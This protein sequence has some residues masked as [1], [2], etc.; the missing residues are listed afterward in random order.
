MDMMLV[1]IIFVTLGIG[2]DDVFVFMDA[3]Q[4]SE[5][6]PEACGSLL[7]RIDYTMHRSTKVSPPAWLWF[8][9]AAVIDPSSD[10]MS[11]GTEPA[12]RVHRHRR[13]IL[14]GLIPCLLRPAVL[15]LQ[16]IFIT[17]LTTLVAFFMTS[18]SDMVNLCA[19][20]LYAGMNIFFLFVLNVLILPSAVVIWS[21]NFSHLP[22][23]VCHSFCLC[24]GDLRRK[25]DEKRQLKEEEMAQR[26]TRV[27]SGKMVPSQV[28]PAPSS[29]PFP[30]ALLL[31]VS[32]P[33]ATSRAPLCF[34]EGG[35]ALWYS[36]ARGGI[37]G[38]VCKGLLA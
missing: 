16:A 17:S 11:A 3:F 32:K 7:A 8:P 25:N 6:V 26:S 31:H 9:Q 15:G 14:P 36:H 35:N 10:V 30:S 27:V 12:E 28:P 34:R 24:C 20:G 22:C 21:R 23:C 13:N 29:L 5:A 19:F 4:Q 37:Y 2:A 33:L 18:I 1:L 38:R